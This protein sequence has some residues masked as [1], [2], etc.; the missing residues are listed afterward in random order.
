MKLIIVLLTFVAAASSQSFNSFRS[1]RRPSR[2]QS[3]QTRTS[4]PIDDRFDGS[5]YH[6]SWRHDGNQKYTGQQAAA[7]CRRLGG[8][9]QPISIETD[10][11]NSFVSRI[12]QSNRLNYIWTGATRSGSRWSWPSGRSFRGIAWSHTGGIG[13]PQPD[14]RDRRGENCLAILNNIFRD[15]IKW[16]DIGC[17]HTK[18]VICERRA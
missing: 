1:F 6:F 8:G 18:Q 3:Q 4:V 16:H 14:N 10:A 12:I 9:W 17:H 7:Y 11:E 5:E 15:G 13:R 2:F